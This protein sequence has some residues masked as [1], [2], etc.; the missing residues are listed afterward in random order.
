[1]SKEEL[2][3]SEIHKLNGVTDNVASSEEDA[4][5]QQRIEYEAIYNQLE[6]FELDKT[7]TA[8]AIYPAYN[9]D[10]CHDIMERN[11]LKVAIIFNTGTNCGSIRTVD[12]E[13]HLG[14]MMQEHGNGGGHP[15]AAGFKVQDYNKLK[16]TLDFI[17]DY[18][19][20]NYP[21]LRK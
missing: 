11:K 15:M 20:D 19:Y 21:H 1:M 4:F 10:L 3:G 16:N 17:D 6:I 5:E 8:F 13:I 9:N 18:I 12:E 2:G 14:D 7:L